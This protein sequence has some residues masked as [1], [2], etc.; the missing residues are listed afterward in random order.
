MV[1]LRVATMNLFGSA[2]TPERREVADA[3]V[4]PHDELAVQLRLAPAAGAVPDPGVRSKT[5]SSFA[6]SRATKRRPCRRSRERRHSKMDEPGGFTVPRILYS[7][8]ATFERRRRVHLTNNIHGL[9]Q[10]QRIETH[11]CIGTQQKFIEPASDAVF[12]G[13]FQSLLKACGTSPAALCG[14]TA[15]SPSFTLSTFRPLKCR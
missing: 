5:V 11:A 2:E 4:V 12:I 1:P 14:G 7:T 8:T 9:R 13:A 15:T 3:Q 6:T 10:I